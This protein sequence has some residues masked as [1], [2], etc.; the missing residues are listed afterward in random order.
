MSSKLIYYVYAYLRKD[1][2]P[3]YIGK[4]SGSRYYQH[5]KNVTVPARNQI[6]FL[7]TKLTN[8]G[9]LALE[10]RLIRWY[11]RLD[12]QTGILENRTD[13]G[14]GMIGLKHSEETKLKMSRSQ[15]GKHEW[16]PS[17][18]TKELM[19]RSKLNMPDDYREKLR[20][21]KLGKPRGPHTAETKAKMAL[22]RAEWWA[23]KKNSTK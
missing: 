8:I 13:G 1:G 23:S 12:K 18:E 22:A 3:Y 21:A 16:T 19:R 9:A 14:E 4:G 15:I 11:G 17:S 5:H 2:S 20:Q 6:V 10:R 7:E